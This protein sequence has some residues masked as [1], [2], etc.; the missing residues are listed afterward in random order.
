MIFMVL[1]LCEYGLSGAEL[2]VTQKDGCL[3]SLKYLDVSAC[4]FG[5]LRKY[6]L[7]QVKVRWP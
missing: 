2:R 5:G 7:T 4:R 6:S 1:Q 3:Q